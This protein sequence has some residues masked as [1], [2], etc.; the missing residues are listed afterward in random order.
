MA[1]TRDQWALRIA[2]VL[3]AVAM[4]VGWD[5]D[6]GSARE[7]WALSIVWGTAGWAAGVHYIKGR[8]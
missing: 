5:A 4:A 1:I 3:I 8:P 6:H 2:W 7:R